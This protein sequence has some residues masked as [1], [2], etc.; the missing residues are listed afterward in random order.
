MKLATLLNCGIKL[1]VIKRIWG[2]EREF[3]KTPNGEL[4]HMALVGPDILD[5]ADITDIR[6]RYY[7]NPLIRVEITAPSLLTPSQEQEFTQKIQ[8]MMGFDCPI[9]FDPK[10]QIEWGDT[11][12]RI[13]FMAIDSAWMPS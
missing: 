3:V 1:P 4:R 8:S 2:K 12:K 9:E 7:Q 5:V 6:I 10:P 13:L 11:D